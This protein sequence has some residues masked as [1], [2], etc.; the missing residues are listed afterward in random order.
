MKFTPNL[1]T[2]AGAY[3]FKFEEDDTED[4]PYLIEVNYRQD[5][6]VAWVAGCEE[7][8]GPLENLKNC[9]VWSSR[10]IPIDEIKPSLI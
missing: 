3:W 10:L 8:D 4:E 1:P 5:K 7:W 6:L 2:V 9:G